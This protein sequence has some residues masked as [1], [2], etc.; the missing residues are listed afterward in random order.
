MK[1]LRQS[2]LIEIIGR[3]AVE[4]QEELQVLLRSEGFDVTQ[5]TISRD[6][7]NLRI[8]K[9]LSGEGTYRYALPS[10]PAEGAFSGRLRTI[11]R[12]SVTAIDS[13]QNLTVIKTLPGMAQ[14][15]CSAIDAMN[16]PA[17]VGT[18]AGD[19][20]AFIAMRDEAAAKELVEQ[21]RDM[22][23]N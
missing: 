12:E 23:E 19:D 13:A 21:L 15:A 1:N 7:K 14:A 3:E 5:A 8:F 9:I 10:A 6:I 22:I 2:K 18:L 17:A 20:T 16:A 11:F 4:T